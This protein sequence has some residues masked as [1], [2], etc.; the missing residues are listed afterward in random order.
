MRRWFFIT[1][2]IWV[3]AIVTVPASAQAPPTDNE[4]H[5]AYCL[6]NFNAR[7]KLN[8]DICSKMLQEEIQNTNDRLKNG[9]L[10]SEE[11]D[12]W[13][14]ILNEQQVATKDCNERR[15]PIKFQQA[16]DRLRSYL[17]SK[18]ILSG[19]NI[20]FIAAP[21]K[22]GENDFNTCWQGISAYNKSQESIECSRKCTAS[23]A[24]NNDN[25]FQCQR[26]DCQSDICKKVDNCDDMSYLPY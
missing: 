25:L 15:P 12:K 4:L 14:N 21:M 1:I 18:G 16:A 23:A 8:L 11:R 7:I 10:S 20:I 3:F 6:G 17:F 13:Q 9:N 24:G 26:H 5:A 19:D 2:F 22:Q